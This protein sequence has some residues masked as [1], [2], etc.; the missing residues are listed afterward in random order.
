MK[1]LSHYLFLFTFLFWSILIEAQFDNKKYDKESFLVGILN[2]YMGNKR[3][4]IAGI[5]DFYYQRIDNFPQGE[6]KNVLFIDSL[7]NSDYSDIYFTNNGAR[8]GI[9]M[10]SY[11]LSVVIDKYYEYKPYYDRVIDGDTLLGLSSVAFE[12]YLKI[13]P[14]L[15]RTINGDTIY[16]AELKNEIFETDKQKLSFLLGAFLRFGMCGTKEGE[17]SKMRIE[18]EKS[19]PN[20]PILHIIDARDPEKVNDKCIKYCFS[21]PN[22]SNKAKICAELLKETGCTDVEYIINEDF[23]PSSCFVIFKP[24]QEVQE[25]IDD[26]ESL[27]RIISE[28]NTTDIEFTS[29]GNKFRWVETIN[30]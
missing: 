29:D 7:F 2:E 19:M 27:K 10:Y 30:K 23:I 26:A 25:L 16:S 6:L 8:I 4:F 21:M 9:E 18:I 12:K 11:N 3:V 13:T 20:S 14:S 15:I 5:D 28:I 24:S 22:V 1:Q 17:P